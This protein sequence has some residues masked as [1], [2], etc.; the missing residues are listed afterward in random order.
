MK[1]S[2]YLRYTIIINQK[3]HYYEIETSRLKIKLWQ[4][5]QLSTKA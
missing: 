5:T 3:Y 4:S 1:Y 2:V